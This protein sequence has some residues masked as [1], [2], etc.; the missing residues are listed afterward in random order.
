M[1]FERASSRKRRCLF[2]HFVQ[3]HHSMLVTSAEFWNNSQLT[4]EGGYAIIYKL[5]TRAAAESRVEATAKKFSKN[6]YKT[7]WQVLVLMVKWNTKFWFGNTILLL[8]LPT[9]LIHIHPNEKFFERVKARFRV[10]PWPLICE[11]KPLVYAYKWEPKL[12]F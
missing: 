11:H 9:G 7:H 2:R 5:S 3:K 12:S 8:V 4:K 10:L 6:F 1:R